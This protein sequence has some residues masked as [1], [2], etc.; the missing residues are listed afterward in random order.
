MTSIARRV[1]RCARTTTSQR[2]LHV[3]MA[4]RAAYFD[5]QHLAV[6]IK[7]LEVWGWRR[8]K[9]REAVPGV[10]QKGSQG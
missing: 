3:C 10:V 9:S 5:T 4:L 7:S 6:A 1:F 2:A 8:L